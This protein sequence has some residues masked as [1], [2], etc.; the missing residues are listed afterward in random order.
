MWLRT[1]VVVMLLFWITL[2]GMAGSLTVDEAVDY[3]LRQN[4]DLRSLRLEEEV[5]KAELQKARLPLIANPTVETNVV[6][7][8]KG[9]DVQR[10]FT[11]YGVAL[12]QTFEVAGQRGF[13]IDVAERELQRVGLEIRD[14][15]RIITSEVRNAFAK[16]LASKRRVEL[17]KES[18]AL[19]EELL[20]FTR[21]KF[22]AGDVSGLEVNV[23]EL[24]Y[25]KARTELLVS[26][27]EYKESILNLQDVMGAAPDANAGI[28]GQL[29][30][31]NFGVPDK[32]DLKRSAL[33]GRPDLQASAVE[34]E[35]TRSAI[36]LAGREAIP[37]VTVSAFYQRDEM[38]NTGG[39]SFSI[40]LPLIDRRQAEKRIAKIRSEQSTIKYPNLKRLIEKEV[41]EGYVNLA[42]SREEIALYSK[43]MV[44]KSLD[45]LDLLNLAFR[46]G[47]VSFYDVQ[48]AQKDALDIQFSYLD[49]LLRAQLAINALKRITGG[50]P[51]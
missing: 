3:T 38:R 21:I 9:G 41:E 15:E 28:E 17:K 4:P 18:V 37:N 45:N 46:E 23:A 39:L 32:E 48:V 26:E 25:G 6:G 44:S 31:E 42:S 16:A 36:H 20:E 7:K 1:S 43:E 24:E 19:K 27:R 49:A 30:T 12:S 47:K 13:R 5:A 22:K 14:K 29:P 10:T 51:K 33:A 34:A 11:D 8:G 35:R 2:P 40:P 50:E